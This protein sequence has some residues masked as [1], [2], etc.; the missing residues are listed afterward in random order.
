MSFLSQ[1]FEDRYF[2]KFEISWAIFDASCVLTSPVESKPNSRM[3]KTKTI[4]VVLMVSSIIDKKSPRP[5]CQAEHRA[6]GLRR[7]T[8]RKRSKLIPEQ[9]SLSSR[10]FLK[11]LK[12]DISGNLRFSSE[13]CERR[14]KRDC[15]ATCAF[16]DWPCS[17]IWM[18]QAQAAGRALPSA[19][20]FVADP[21]TGSIENHHK[22]V[23]PVN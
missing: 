13:Y 3:I 15:S 12:I 22:S 6:T 18:L 7:R 17:V 11:R 4:G 10:Y 9:L 8:R 19:D 5:G 21:I 1:A 23:G 20:H 2:R 14:A 16:S